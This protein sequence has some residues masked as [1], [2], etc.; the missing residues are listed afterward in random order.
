MI[1]ETQ[2]RALLMDINHQLAQLDAHGRIAWA[3]EHLPQQQVLA[4][5]FGVQSALMLHLMNEVAPGIP[6]IFIDTG[7]HFPETYAFVDALTERLALRLNVYRSAL[8][9]AWQ[10]ARYG[11][12]WEQG[13]E[14]IEAYNEENKVAPMQQALEELKVGTWYSGVRRSQAASRAHLGVVASQWG[15][16]KVHPVVDWTDQQVYRYLTQHQL[17]YHPLY[18]EGYISIGDWHTTRA[19]KD[20]DNEEEARFFG[21]LRECGLHDITED[22]RNKN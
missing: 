11:K 9:A 17:P 19:L 10:E 13:R 5:S 1:L 14:A 22:S 18:E 21:L 4:S 20:I 2:E 7:Y 8:S 6:V 16:F 3:L 12:R 15:R